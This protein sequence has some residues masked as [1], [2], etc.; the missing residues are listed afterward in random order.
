MNESDPSWRSRP[1][2]NL[3]DLFGTM[4]APQDVFT[5]SIETGIG[6]KF[7]L[8]QP[9]LFRC[10]SLPDEPGH[11]SNE[12]PQHEVVLTRSF[13]FANVPT[14]QQQW[15]NVMKPALSKGKAHAV[16][17]LQNQPIVNVTWQE[18]M[19]F[20]ELLT[21]SE[22]SRR[23]GYRYRLPT[24]AEWEYAC[25]AESTTPYFVG[26]TLSTQQANVGD[27]L[28]T[29]PS[30]VARFE[31]NHF[32]LFDMHGL[33]WEWCSD[34]YGEDTYTIRLQRDPPGPETGVLRVLRG[35]SWRH[36]PSCARSAYRNALAPHQ[37]DRAT[38][39]RVV[40]EVSA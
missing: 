4:S 27:T 12:A 35:G 9:G 20:C 13:Y 22:E 10:G 28:G 36:S 1:R 19:H 7:L 6:Q 16:A 31:P 25:R 5:K 17:V 38:G 23:L 21:Q 26:T 34:W 30:P 3:N 15:N 2:P 32:G 37:K 39:F 40:L 29:G 11:R 8:L 14:T 33:V 24:E 18:A